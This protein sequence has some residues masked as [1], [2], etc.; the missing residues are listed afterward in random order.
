M[1]FS[2]TQLEAIEHRIKKY[3]Y[4]GLS[5]SSGLTVSELSHTHNNAGRDYRVSTLEKYAAICDVPLWFFMFIAEVDAGRIP[6]DMKE[7]MKKYVEDI[8][9][10]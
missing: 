6:K 3:S 7:M 5:K 8:L 10:T 9:P 2:K 1:K 4:R